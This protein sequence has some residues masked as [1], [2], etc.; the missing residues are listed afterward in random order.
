[1]SWCPLGQ[2]HSEG[3]FGSCRAVNIVKNLLCCLK[4]WI[5]L[6]KISDSRLLLKMCEVYSINGSLLLFDSSWF[7]LIEVCVL[8]FAIIPNTFCCF[9]QPLP[10]RKPSHRYWSWV[11]LPFIHVLTMSFKYLLVLTHLLGM[12]RHLS[13]WSCLQKSD[14]F[15]RLWVVSHWCVLNTILWITFSIP[16]ETKERRKEIATMIG[17]QLGAILCPAGC[18]WL[19]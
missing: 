8:Q 9:D 2:I 15:F 7:E 3:L 5:F 18:F 1:M 4:F 13:L 11:S 6:L 10:Y 19:S 12:C 14:F 16:R 17:F